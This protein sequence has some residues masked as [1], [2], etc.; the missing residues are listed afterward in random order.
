MATWEAPGEPS[1]TPIAA[2]WQ[3]LAASLTWVVRFSRKAPLVSFGEGLMSV[4]SGADVRVVLCT[5]PPEHATNVAR[6]LLEQRLAACVNVIP[7]VRSLYWWN[8]EVAEDG[9]SLLVIKTPQSRFADLEARLHEIHPYDVPEVLSL[10]VDEGANTYL[11]WLR[12]SVAC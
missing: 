1:R 4:E 5:C 9:E 7:G 10:S 2:Y 8:D 12:E 3:H 11:S 6:D